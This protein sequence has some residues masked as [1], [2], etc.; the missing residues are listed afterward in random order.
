MKG[1]K[2]LKE[3]GSLNVELINNLPLEEYME[4]MGN[5]TQEQVEEYLCKTPINESKNAMR[6]ITVDYT[7]EEDI[8]LRGSVLIE[9]F[10]NNEREKYDHKQ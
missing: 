9:D 5:L 4:T 8:T 2:I 6:A 10:I 3:N 1:S 7:M